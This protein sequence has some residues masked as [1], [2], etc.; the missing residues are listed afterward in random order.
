[1][2]HFE[3]AASLLKQFDALRQAAPGITPG[4]V[5][6]QISPSEQ[7]VMLQ[8]LLLAAGKASATKQV[9]AVAGPSLV[10][11]DPRVLPAKLELFAL[12]V[13]L[14][15]LRSVQPAE[16]DGQ[17]VLLVGARSGVLVV[18]PEKPG[19]A[20]RSFVDPEVASQMGFSRAVIW[21]HGVWACHGDAGIVGWDWGVMDRPKMVLRPTHLT[22]QP[23]ASNSTMTSI[24]M[25]K[26]GSPRNLAVLDENRLIFSIGERLLTLDAGGQA[27]ALPLE[28]RSE[29][30][31]ILPDRRSVYVIR[32]DGSITTHDPA[33]LA[34]SAEERRGGKINAAA[35]LPWLGSAR[36]LLATDEGPI[37]CLGTEDQLVTQYCSAHR[38]L[39]IITAAADWVIAVSADRQRLVLWNS[40]EGRK[41]AVEIS[42]SS[43]AKHRV[44]DVDLG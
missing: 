21:R 27:A 31:A 17:A 4:A 37:Q 24:E 12:P 22:G 9:W 25:N 7:G 1:V 20:P 39:R 38:G 40:W 43:V 5:L 33:T 28:S 26:P 6:Q 36:I 32:E 34:V 18:N 35:L 2:E 30:I 16:I 14:G 11:V 44:A 41:P 42:V 3:K 10:K 8:T 15:P 13:A 29:I 23:A 19:D